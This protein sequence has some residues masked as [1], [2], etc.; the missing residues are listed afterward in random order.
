MVVPFGV[1]VGDFFSGLEFLRQL[2]KALK[3]SSGSSKDFCDLISE[4]ESLEHA[5]TAVNDIQ[6][7]QTLGAQK[8]AIIQAASKC[9]DTISEF[10]LHTAKYK[11]SLI[12]GGSG[13]K[14]LDGLK[15]IRWA[16]FKKEDVQRLRA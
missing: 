10:L 13:N 6:V 14:W 16:L 11:T 5:L 12:S 7:D 2:I 3:D 8:D 1:S 15:K 9:Q 4:L